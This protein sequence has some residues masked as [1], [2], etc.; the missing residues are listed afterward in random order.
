MD[1]KED[2]NVIKVEDTRMAL[3]YL[4]KE[5]FNNPDEELTMI[6]VTGTTGKT[7]TTHMIKD[8]LNNIGIK[9]GLIGSIGIK[10]N[11]KIIHTNN[12]TP[13]SYEIFKYLKEMKD[14]GITHITMECS[15]QAFKLNRLAGIILEY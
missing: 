9:C 14:S 8:I 7:T 10:Y 3:A 2:I 15:S 4:S 12:T 11:D 6:G 5:Y 13:E 1:I